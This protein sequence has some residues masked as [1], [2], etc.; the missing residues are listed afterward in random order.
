[1]E[2][3]NLSKLHKVIERIDER[4]RA[5]VSTDEL[6]QNVCFTQNTPKDRIDSCIADLGKAFELY[7]EEIECKVKLLPYLS[8]LKETLQLN[9]HKTGIDVLMV[10]MS[11][12]GKFQQLLRNVEQQLKALYAQSS[13]EFEKMTH[14]EILSM[15]DP[16]RRNSIDVYMTGIRPSHYNAVHDELMQEQ[17]KQTELSDKIAHLNQTTVVEIMSLEEF[18][19]KEKK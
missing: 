6:V 12:S 4:I 15:I 13:R 9:N 16:E 18:Q 3:M 2:K 17:K 14:A 1:M 10:Q 19:Q 8:Y 7:R 5:G 11:V